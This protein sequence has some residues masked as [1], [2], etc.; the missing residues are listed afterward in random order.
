[1]PVKLTHYQCFGVMRSPSRSIIIYK[2]AADHPIELPRWRI[3]AV[4]DAT[5]KQ[6][7]PL[8]ARARAA[9]LGSLR[10]GITPSGPMPA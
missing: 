2:G 6:G 5:T 3:K 4:D 9:R 8:P 1:M 7:S 10:V